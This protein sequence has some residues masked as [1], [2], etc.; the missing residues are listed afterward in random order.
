MTWKIQ[1]LQITKTIEHTEESFEFYTTNQ[2]TFAHQS[3]EISRENSGR[4][5]TKIEIIYNK[6]RHNLINVKYRQ[7]VF[8]SVGGAVV[9]SFWEP[10]GQTK[11]MHSRQRK[12]T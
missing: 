7:M 1:K 3:R 8:R 9:G 4:H 2:S 6:T 12:I 10:L 5:T 11:V